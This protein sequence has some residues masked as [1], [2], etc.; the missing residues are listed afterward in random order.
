MR[1]SRSLAF[2]LL[3]LLLVLSQQMGIA[4]GMSH[5][6]ESRGAEPGEQQEQRR[7]GKSL[8]PDQSCAQCLAFAQIG[9]ALGTPCYSFPA[10]HA[11]A[12]QTI[13]RPTPAA[14]LRTVCVFLS[15]A[16]PVLS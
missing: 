9:S 13:T 2:A 10:T 14:C 1:F 12:P 7:P 11:A 8:A 6:S 5:W 4:H 16:P 15:R 3:S